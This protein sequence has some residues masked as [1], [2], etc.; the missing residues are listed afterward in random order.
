LIFGLNIKQEIL[1]KK[2]DTTKRRV[3]SNPWTMHASDKTPGNPTENSNC[4]GLRALQILSTERRWE[5][6]CEIWDPS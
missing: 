1:G 4:W 5:D 2:K 6:R 3:P